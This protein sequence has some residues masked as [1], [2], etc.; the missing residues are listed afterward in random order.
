[1]DLRSN[2]PYWLLRNG[3][4]HTYPSLEKNSSAEV[5]IIGG[6]ISGALT[7]WYLSEAGFN[8][9]LVDRRHIG[10]G[11]TAASTALL[12]YEIDTPLHE[13]VNKVGEA[14]AIKS[15]LLGL[16]AIDDLEE[17]CGQLD[18][19]HFFTRRPSFQF[20]SYKKDTGPLWKEYQLRKK[21]GISLQ[22]LDEKEVETKFGFKKPAGLLSSDAGEA[23]AYG[24]THTLLQKCIHRGV[25][26]YDHTNVTDIRR[27]KRGIELI[28]G[29]GSTIKAKKLVI[30]S[31]Y[32]SQQYIPFKVQQLHS[33]FAIISEPVTGN[34][35]WFKNALIWET[36]TP[37]LY[38][39]TTHD[40]RV[41]IGGKDVPLSD[42]LKRDKL[43]ATKARSLEEDFG[44]LFPHIPFRTDFKWA[45]TFASTKDGLPYMGSIRQLPHTYFALGFGGNGITFSVLAGQAITAAINGK[46]NEMIDLFSFDR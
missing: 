33:T 35:P 44:K 31:G 29:T 6:G 42:P 17:I 8:V 21:N 14:N 10:M 16:K 28:T 4:L 13:L 5:A 23:D 24:L 18:C 43:L 19:T 30:A 20:A 32:E 7:A 46:K 36:R 25:Q 12:Q 9:A 26:V 34:K 3:I 45:G 39:R 41:L 40:H 2:N 1:M 27:N 15:Y 11:S 37:Y 22:W 38:L